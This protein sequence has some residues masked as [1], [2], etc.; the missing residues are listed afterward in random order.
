MMSMLLPPPAMLKSQRTPASSNRR[1][2]RAASDSELDRC[3]EEASRCAG[4]VLIE[5]IINP[6][7]Y[8]ETLRA[9]RG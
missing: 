2:F 9:V 6:A 4:P 8:A 7:S 1:A 3:L 5:A